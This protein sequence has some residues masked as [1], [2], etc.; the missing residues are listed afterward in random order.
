MIS[1]IICRIIFF[2]NVSLM[3]GLD[4]DVQP[5][6]INYPIDYPGE[7]VQPPSVQPPPV[8]NINNMSDVNLWLKSFTNSIVGLS[9]MILNGAPLNEGQNFFTPAKNLL[10]ATNKLKNLVNLNNQ[11]I[12]KI[13][14]KLHK[15]IKQTQ[16]ANRK[17]FKFVKTIIDIRPWINDVY[18]TNMSIVQTI[19][20]YLDNTFVINW[21]KIII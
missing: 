16:T 7:Y 2:N 12:L 1:L 5:P 8:N 18:Q 10:E 19:H 21:N 3:E 14:T 11:C 13:N 15:N 20:P 17:P 9:T 6:A 4:G